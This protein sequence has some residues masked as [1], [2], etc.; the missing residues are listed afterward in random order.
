MMDISLW[1]SLALA[2]SFVW[3]T[4][5]DIELHLRKLDCTKEQVKRHLDQVVM[6]RTEA[7]LAPEHLATVAAATVSHPA[8]CSGRARPSLVR[9][10][11]RWSSDRAFIVWSP[12]MRRS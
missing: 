7:A 12:S 1:T 9:S 8:G 11:S 10:K 5:E 4:M 3:P 6:S 2:Y